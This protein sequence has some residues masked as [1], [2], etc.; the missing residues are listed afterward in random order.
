MRTRTDRGMTLIE[1]TVVLAIVAIMAAMTFGGWSMLARRTASQ[2]AAHD[3]FSAISIARARATQTGNDVWFIVYPRGPASLEGQGAYYIFEDI[4]GL[5]GDPASAFNFANHFSPANVSP[6]AG[7]T[8]GR[9]FQ[10]GR[11]SDYA[12]GS[13]AFGFHYKFGFEPPFDA[14]DATVP[15]VACSFC[16]PSAPFGDASRGAIVFDAN[17]SATFVDDRG[18]VLAPHPRAV[19]L[20][21]KSGDDAKGVLFAVSAATG[22]IAQ[23]TK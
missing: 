14:L 6:P 13:V 2:N 16:R 10:A 15:D 8:E 7:A 19:S 12:G 4:D 20:A 23:Y 1:V 17:G 5:F 9:L 11:M 18:D 22:F 21:V 3:L